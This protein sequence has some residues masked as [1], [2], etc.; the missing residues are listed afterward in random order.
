MHQDLETKETIVVAIL[1][2]TGENN[3]VLQ[4]ALQSAPETPGQDVPLQR[5][6]SLLALLPPP[7][8][9]SGGRRYATY[10]GSLTTPPC[11]EPVRWFILLD[12]SHVSAQQV[13]DFM[14]FGS[15]GAT[16]QL[17]ARPEQPV[18]GRAVEYA[19]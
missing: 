8:G 12:E 4:A 17:N 13:L 1:L 11:T 19:L 2:H 18:D 9:P 14:S 3:P 5:A 15:N 10:E 7:L 16:L 6:I